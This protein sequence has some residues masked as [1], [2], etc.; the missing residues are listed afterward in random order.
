MCNKKQKQREEKP[1]YI[2]LIVYV[3]PV[4]RRIKI[5][6]LKEENWVV[7]PFCFLYHING[8]NYFKNYFFFGYTWACR[9]FPGLG[10]N[11]S[12]SSNQNHS[13]DNARPS[14]H[15]TAREL[16]EC[17]ILNCNLGVPWWLSRLRIQHSLLGSGY[18]SGVGSI[19]GPWTSA[20]LRHSQ[21]KTK[22][23]SN[24][25][26][27]SHCNLFQFLVPHVQSLEIA[28]PS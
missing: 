13:S 16:K 27:I 21:N 3:Q 5:L 10:S 11:S 12:H 20:C 2:N 14:T 9:F 17:I 6:T 23:N 24:N 15:C 28:P 18:C 4:S 26:N 19:P 25:K 7:V 1:Y 22:Q 8:T